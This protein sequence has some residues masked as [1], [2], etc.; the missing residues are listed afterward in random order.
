MSVVPARSRARFVGRSA[1]SMLVAASAT[2]VAVV[3][4]AAPAAAAPAL[5]CADAIYIT[6]NSDGRI[7]RVNPVDGAVSSTSVYDGRIGA[8]AGDQINQLGIGPGGTTAVSSTNVATG[9]KIVKYDA[10]LGQTTTSNKAAG[11]GGVAG[12]VDLDNGL[13]YYGGYT[14]D[15]FDLYAYNPATNASIG[16]VAT[17]S[18]PGEGTNGDLA[19][20]K[21]GRLFLVKASG[22]V[23]TLFRVDQDIPTATTSPL[24]ALTTTQL[25]SGPVTAAINGMTFAS[26]GF[27]YLGSSLRLQKTNPITGQPVN[28][29][30]TVPFSGST[31]STDL[32]S[33]A[34]PSTLTVQ[35]NLPDGRQ[36][37][38]GGDQFTVGAG[39]GDYDGSPSFPTGTTTGGDAGPQAGPTEAATGIVLPGTPMTPTLTPGPGTDLTNY[40]ITYRCEDVSTSPPTL[41]SSGSGTA[42]AVTVPAGGTGASIVCTYDAAEPKP[43]IS[44]DKTV[45]AT[46]FTRAGQKLTYTFAIKNTGNTPLGD[47]RLTDPMPNLSTPVCADTALGGTLAPSATT[48]CTATYTVTAQDIAD[49]DPIDNSASV[50]GTPG[51]NQGDAPSATD[52]ASSAYAAAAPTAVDDSA[53]AAFNSPVTLPG[54]RNDTAGSSAILPGATVFT[55]PG[56]TN[57]GKTLDVP[58][59]GVWT[60]AADG[61][62]TFTPVA[63]FAGP[64]T[65]VDYRVTDENG[66]TD[67]GTLTV[68]VGPG[69]INTADEPGTTQGTSVKVN[70]LGND[71]PSQTAT[72][73][74]GT[75]D[76]A[77][78]RFG[79][80]DQPDGATVTDG[81]K[82]L[83]VPNQGVYTID[84]DGS[85]TFAPDPNFSGTTTPVTYSVTDQT[86]TTS[87]S[88]ITVDVERVDPTATND[89]VRTQFGTP[90]I[91]P[92]G[93][94][95]TAGVG[96]EIDQNA[97]I[98]TSPD[99]TNG[100]K[101]LVTDQGTWTVQDDGTV[102]FVP[103]DGYSGL[104]PPVEY[105]ITDVNGQKDTGEL[106]VQVRPG[107]TAVPDTATTKQNVNVQISPL[108]DDTA[109]TRADGTAGKLDAASVVFPAGDQP[110][111]AEVSDGGKTLTVAGQGVYTVADNGV[112]TFDPAPGFRGDADPITYAVTD[113]A[114]N[115]AT[116]TI[117]VSV[118]GIDPV[119]SNDAT[120]TPSSTPARLDLVDNDRPGDESAPLDPTSIVFSPDGLPDGTTVSTDGKVLTVPGQGEYSVDADG[121]VTFTPEAGFEGPATPFT[122]TISDANGQTDTA[123]GFVVVGAA[124]LAR[125]DSLTTV[126][127]TPLTDV[128]ILANDIAGDQG[129]PCTTPG[130]PDGCDT[131]TLV[132]GSVVF[133]A[134]DQPEGALLAPDGKTLTV[135]GEGV[136][137]LDED[138]LLTFTPEAGF[139]GPTSPVTYAVT[140]S[141]GQV[142]KGSVEIGVA[143]VTPAA[144]DDSA[145]TPFNTPVTL[146]GASNDTAGDA[147]D[148]TPAP[149]V[150]A[151]TVFPTDGQPAGAVVSVDGRTLTLDGEG[152]Y[153][154]A[155]NGTIEFTPEDDFSGPTTAVTYQVQDSNGTTA[156]A[157]LNVTVQ[158]GP[159]GL[160]DTN[161]T[162]QGQPISTDVVGDDLAGQNADGT[163]GTIVP[164]TLVF[165]EDD[166]PEGAT[167]ADDGK[168]LT[169]PGEGVY[170]VVDGEVL[171]TPELDFSGAASPITYSVQDNNG[172]PATATLSIE[173]TAVTPTAAADSA[174]TAF[175]T[176]V[177]FDFI[178]TDEAGD[179]AVPLVVDSA[180]F[181]ADDN[182]PAWT[183]SEDGKTLTIENQGEF[184]LND[185]GTVT[186]TPE[187]GFDGA[188]AA[189]TYTVRDENGTTA[190]ATVQVTVRPGPEA[191]PNTATTAQNVDIEVTVLG[192][193]TPG[194][195]AGGDPS[196]FVLDTVRFP[197]QGQPE[198]VTI[199]NDGKRLVVPGEGTYTAGDDGRITFDPEA[200]FANEASPITYAVDD[201]LGNT[202]TSTLTITV[203]SID[204]IA[205]ADQASTTPGVA[206]TLPAVLDDAAGADSAP[207]VPGATVFPTDGQPE[208]AVAADDGKTLT[209]DGE[210]VWTVGDDGSITFTP[211]DDFE[212]DASQVVYQIEDAN[213]TTDTATLDV[214]VRVGPSASD[215]DEVTLQG[216]PVTVEALVNDSPGLNADGSDATWNTGSIV[217]PVDGQP[218]DA[219]V[220]D[221]G[222]TLTVPDEGVY[223]VQDDGRITFAPEPQFTGTTSA[224]TYEV[225]NS[226]DRSVT[227]ELTIV[228]DPVVPTAVDDS[229]RTNFGRAATIDVLGNDNGNETAAL[230]PG[231]LV[232][233]DPA[234]GDR[235]EKV[236][237]RGEG[238]YEVVDG[239]VVF[240]PAR[241][242][243]GVTTPL[244]YEVSDEN[245]TVTRAELTVTVE[246][247]GTATKDEDSTG[248]GEAVT[249]SVLDNDVAADGEKLVP[250][251]VCLLPDGP[252]GP[253]VKTAERDG[254][255]TWVVN[256][257]GTITFTPA[258]GYSGTATI[259]YAV[260]DTAGNVY[261]TD[262]DIEVREPGIVNGVQGL[263]P[264]AGG[265]EL[266][267]LVLGLL[268]L[269]GGGFALSRRRKGYTPRH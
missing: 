94:N 77:T 139:S 82:T 100:G 202:A 169:V 155:T 107:P 261:V 206:V 33:C 240:T 135:P 251:S 27:L 177:T 68:R 242:F 208:G 181:E 131:G 76:P 80:A 174:F 127:N 46:Q 196:T 150:P 55:S 144:T 2:L 216:D 71:T 212:G 229:A 40:A 248:P 101:T 253:C 148:G 198:G 61:S 64:A 183:I 87:G 147:G 102:R 113:Q 140:D 226:L 39:G 187:A 29:P 154:I 218:E 97:T 58:R 67:T 16:R 3:A 243:T 151:S 59:E 123:Q 43:G 267:L 256:D 125:P 255:G 78:V 254:V 122:Y 63:G 37:A 93:T 110:D 163:D 263:L 258:D 184:V 168:K 104:T 152:V 172:N 269:A 95:D 117:T 70:V 186:F 130:V 42:A 180:T 132:A 137:S 28:T 210:G 200:G 260:T 158:P 20:D 21:T 75:F 106:R 235:V 225:T 175:D 232:L 44:L 23:S 30:T 51:L 85:V 8:G 34:G 98:L 262:L 209:V 215:D 245:G 161:T 268:A 118:T 213:G 233:I 121:L 22:T 224:I 264:D 128:Q 165:P 250:G 219:T 26:D 266:A 182:N 111:G 138:G 89:Q 54:A 52:G 116:S 252:S 73:G 11:A 193:D 62:V 38:G 205:N 176:A 145:A 141:Y 1:L 223:T 112:V 199:D 31:S 109:G 220:S 249:V 105:Q 134:D 32:G 203:T 214:T 257:D 157:K 24:P 228:V 195:Q 164:A 119:A 197:A 56:A 49:G 190:T 142:A 191:E 146:L 90:A 133:T 53:R 10:A 136:Y 88:T 17:I 74:A 6:D 234:T 192:N 14:G 222:K 159:A 124:P 12:G 179:D 149:L 99:A 114:G 48:T 185:D 66:L 36:D 162:L 15:T 79:A 217:F 265:T 120:K 156:T 237:V 57:G 204:P 9:A 246:G 244:G 259:A 83:T 230:V 41:I 166:Q 170:T 92:A 178:G 241:G 60:I 35:V 171:F 84:A 115:V 194:L 69:P 236:S 167:V 188:T 201:E 81:G 47:L 108:L 247:G 238:T 7:K 103:A 239:K 126:Q 173:V 129:N 160:D 231:T 19:F 211:K 13:Y 91:L 227:A 45:D 65:P 207:L 221:D 86:G 189:P 153:V 18:V 4:T 143:A 50:T 72:G 96:R 5:A 25:S